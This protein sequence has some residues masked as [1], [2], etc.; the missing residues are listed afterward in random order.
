MQLW[1]PSS[2]L[3]CMHIYQIAQSLVSSAIS[4]IAC[5]WDTFK[6][7]CPICFVP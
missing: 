7:G 2:I 4:L 6:E 5:Y 1:T 3:F